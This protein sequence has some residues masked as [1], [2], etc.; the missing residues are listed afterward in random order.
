MIIIII[1]N[2]KYNSPSVNKNIPFYLFNIYRGD[3]V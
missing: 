1:N 2:I 3:D